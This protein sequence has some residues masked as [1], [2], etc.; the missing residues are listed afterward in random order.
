MNKTEF[1]EYLISEGLS[2]S[3]I[4]DVFDKYLLHDL[5]FINEARFKILNIMDVTTLGAEYLKTATNSDTL[6]DLANCH[7]FGKYVVENYKEN[8]CLCKS[9]DRV[10]EWKV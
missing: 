6:P 3:E 4:S 10:I 5:S 7:E 9:T 1:R 2:R 8:Y